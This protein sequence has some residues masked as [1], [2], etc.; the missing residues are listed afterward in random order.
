MK[1][2]FGLST[3]F[4]GRKVP[5]LTEWK[6]I[7][8]AG[9]DYAEV[10]LLGY[11]EQTEPLCVLTDFIE[12][13]VNRI[14][15]AGMELWTL[16]LP[17]GPNTDVTSKRID[18]DFETSKLPEARILKTLI[19]CGHSFGFS[20][21]VLHA[22]FEPIEEKE[23]ELRLQIG[24]E[25][26][27]KIAAYVKKLGCDLAVECLP[28][29]CMGNTGE[30]CQKLIKNTEAKICMD[31]NHLFHETPKQFIEKL[32]NSIVTTH[33]SDNDGIDERHLIPGKGIIDF[34][35]AFQAL[36]AI[37]PYIPVTF[38]IRYGEE[39]TP[40]KIMEGFFESLGDTTTN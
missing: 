38:E 12:K 32:G 37:N 33:I 4:Y 10:A 7:R 27:R 31:I 23:R 13:S 29:T 20:A 30:E 2:K 8:K 25:N 39:I 5:E 16:H 34:K 36:D 11:D 15:E 26:I 35:D 14:R 9:F 28:R 40:K 21:F 19:D 6:K 18:G 1:R 17:Y 3:S 22:S 24:N